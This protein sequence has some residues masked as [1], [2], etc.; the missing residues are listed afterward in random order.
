VLIA[1]TAQVV[2]NVVSPR[3]SLESGAR[4]EG[5]I[6]TTKEEP[7]VASPEMVSMLAAGDAVTR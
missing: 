1:A 3:V 5:G 6:T 2:G 4:F 7:R